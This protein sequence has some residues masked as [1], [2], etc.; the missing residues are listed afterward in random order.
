MARKLL[1]ASIALTVM[2]GLTSVGGIASA[3]VAASPTTASDVST[4]K[5]S[6]LGTILVSGGSAVYTMKTSKASC[7]AQC[8]KTWIP[9]LLP[10][11]VMTAT[12]GSGAD[13]SK[14]GTMATSD[15]ALQ[16]TYGGQPL[17]WYSKDKG[18]SQA[19]G[20]NVSDKWGKWSSVVTVKSSSGSGNNGG[21]SNSGTG[22][23][24]F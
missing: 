16:V 24:A 8:A 6:K 1:T 13:A 5:N 20:N 19:K 23:T 10:S 22:G 7:T 3:N 12:A 15:G 11:G 2:V 9:V 14:L 4:V 21:G 18:S 17:Y